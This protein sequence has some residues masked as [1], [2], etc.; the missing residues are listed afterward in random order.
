MAPY[1]RAMARMTLDIDTPVL[2]D[3][4]RLQERV[5]KPLGRLVTDLLSEALTRH[6][7]AEEQRPA[8]FR[9]RS[10]PMQ[11]RVDLADKEAV[12]AA[13]DRRS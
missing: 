4:K 6:R 11:A 3:L 7:A 2:Q 8:E 5:R 1:D 12:H 13:L 9:W 10:R